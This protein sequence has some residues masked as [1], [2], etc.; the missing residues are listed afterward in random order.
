MMA[1]HGVEREILFPVTIRYDHA[2][3]AADG[4]LSFAL[5]DHDI[6]I[7]RFLWLVLDD[8]VRVRFH[9]E[10]LADPIGGGD[11]AASPNAGSDR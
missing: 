6:P 2:S 11:E 5:T 1:L 9:F 8:E 3:L 4:E 10:A 7:P